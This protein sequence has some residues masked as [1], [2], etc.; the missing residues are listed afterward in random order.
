[1]RHAKSTYGEEYLRSPKAWTDFS[2]DTTYAHLW[3]AIAYHALHD[4][5]QF[6]NHAQAV[7]GSKLPK[8]MR[9]E[10][11]QRYKEA[12]VVPPTG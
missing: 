11:E 7:A 12:G 1:M 6:E 9:E 4:K 3:L 5:P 2:T 8:R 10:I